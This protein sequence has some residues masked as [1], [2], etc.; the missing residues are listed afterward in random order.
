[1]A[2]ARDIYRDGYA[3][4]IRGAF[5]ELC[6]MQSYTVP[7]ILRSCLEVAQVHLRYALGWANRLGDAGLRGLC[8][9]LL[10]WVAAKLR[11]L[12]E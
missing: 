8:L 12:P 1:M 2:T 5:A 4:N 9:K 7:S 11:R 6:E 3:S 10:G